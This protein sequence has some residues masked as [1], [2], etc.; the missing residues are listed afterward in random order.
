MPD[1]SHAPPLNQRPC[2]HGP[3]QQKEIES[4]VLDLKANGLIK[5]GHDTWSSPVRLVQKKDGSWRFSV[6]Y[7]TLNEIPVKDA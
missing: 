2:R 4:Q 5:E 3:V 1:I 6:D 7:R